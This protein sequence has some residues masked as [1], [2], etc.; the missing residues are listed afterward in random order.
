MIKINL[1][2]VERAVSR[3]RRKGP[4]TFN[5]GQQATVAGSALLIAAALLIGWRYWSLGRQSRALDDDIAQAQAETVR[6]R[7][8]I[9]QV[10]QFDDQKAQLQQRVA[11]IEQL[12]ASQTGPV[13]MLDQV[14]RS[15]PP[16]LWLTE[17]KQDPKK[18]D[19]LLVDG[20]CTSLTGLSDFVSNLEASGYFKRS[21]EIVSTQTENLP[22][23]QVTVVKFEIRAVFQPP[24]AAP[25]PGAPPAA[26]PATAKSGG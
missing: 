14:S 3:P 18:P 2:T 21:I 4:I 11:L 10:Q 26:P 16:M 7:S 5:V 20:R 17:L 6:L 13:H 25:A 24:A 1:L 15:L 8:V 9:Q 12:R 19:E 22:N 23:Q